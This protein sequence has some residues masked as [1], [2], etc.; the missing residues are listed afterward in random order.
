MSREADSILQWRRGLSARVN[1]CDHEMTDRPPTLEGAL[2]LASRDGRVCP[3]PQQWNHFYEL[4]PNK[5]RAGNGWEPPLPLI[6]RAWDDTPALAKALRLEEQ[7]RWA[8]KHGV[9]HAVA[10]FLQLLPEDQ[11][12]HLGD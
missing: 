1:G 4:L 12:Y 6:L 3:L 5:R 8:A 10:E 2:E 9:L 11:W 7:I